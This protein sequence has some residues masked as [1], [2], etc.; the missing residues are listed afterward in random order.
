MLECPVCLEN[1]TSEGSTAPNVLPCGHSVCQVTHLKSTLTATTQP[2]PLSFNTDLHTPRHQYKV[3]TGGSTNYTQMQ[4]PSSLVSSVCRCALTAYTIKSRSGGFVQ[5]GLPSTPVAVCFA[6]CLSLILLVV[7][8]TLA[9]SCS[10]S[11]SYR[12]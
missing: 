4:L 1:F 5:C 8:L 11:L 7:S 10:L 2:H 9:C 6:L 3:S 12:C